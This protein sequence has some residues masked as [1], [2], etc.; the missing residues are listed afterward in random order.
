MYYLCNMKQLMIIFMVLFS[1]AVSAQ[2]F[3]SSCDCKGLYRIG[4]QDFTMCEVFL[5]NY[6]TLYIDSELIIIKNVVT[7]DQNVSLTMQVDGKPQ[8]FINQR[9]RVGESIENGSTQITIY[10]YRLVNLN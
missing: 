5:D 4:N 1:T 3:T 6:N 7:L 9:K 2:K 10:F 8:S